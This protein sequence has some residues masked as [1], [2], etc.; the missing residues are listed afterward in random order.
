[1]Y[2]EN[3]I[4]EL[5]QAIEQL[6]SMPSPRDEAKINELQE[7]KNFC[8]HLKLVKKTQDLNEAEMKDIARI[9]K[10]ISEVQFRMDAYA[11]EIGIKKA[12]EFTSNKTK[13]FRSPGM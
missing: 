7:H 6:E 4:T 8:K 1:M 12:R 3:L 5:T 2:F 13:G 11:L 9:R 10:T